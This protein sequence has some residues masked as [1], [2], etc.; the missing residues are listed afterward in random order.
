MA[1]EHIPAGTEVKQGTYQCN[2]CANEYECTI[3]GEKLPM[4]CVCDSMS[5]RS[6]QLAKSS[7]RKGSQKES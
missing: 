3:D 2:A 6:R 5:W 4:C 7:P 1:K